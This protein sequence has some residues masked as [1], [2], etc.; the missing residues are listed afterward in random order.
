M[1]LPVPLVEFLGQFLRSSKNAEVQSSRDEL[2]A[3]LRGVIADLKVERDYF[4]GRLE[5]AELRYAPIRTSPATREAQVPAPTGIPA[6][7]RKRPWKEVVRANRL[8]LAAE[9]ER[10]REAETATKAAEQA[11]AAVVESVH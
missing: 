6:P 2:V 10:A 11:R 8:S 1:E 9:A 4:K 7:Q 5:L 3:T